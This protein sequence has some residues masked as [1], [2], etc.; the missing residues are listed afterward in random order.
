MFENC[1][2][3]T[4]NKILINNYDCI[5]KFCKGCVIKWN[6]KN[7]TC[8]LCRSN[9]KKNNDNYIINI[10]P[11]NNIINQINILPQNN[12]G[13]NNEPPPSYYSERIPSNYRER[14]IITDLYSPLWGIIY[15]SVILTIFVVLFETFVV[16]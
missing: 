7:K 14:N 1:P 2:I 8:P 16:S 15:A 4:E 6:I 13:S 3:C 10:L 12:I 5:H 9:I 11:E